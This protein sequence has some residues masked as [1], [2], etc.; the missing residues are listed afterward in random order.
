[1]PTYTL[2]PV[3]AGTTDQP[4]GTGTPTVYRFIVVRSIVL[5]GD[6]LN[7]VTLDWTVMGIGSAPADGF[8]FSLDGVLP[9]G[10]I[11]FAAGATHADNYIEF[12]SVADAIGEFDEGFT[13][14]VLNGTLAVAT[15]DG[16]IRNDDANE[17]SGTPGAEQIIGTGLADVLVGIGDDRLEGLGG[18]DVYAI[19]D[20]RLA[21]KSL[22]EEACGGPYSG[23]RGS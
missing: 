10:S 3:D 9:G 20:G 4:E 13:V 21:G 17:I 7:E 15:I 1:M 11:H 14:A 6:E 8:D 2:I 23:W 18:D 16:I 12:S 22:V 19:R 5:D